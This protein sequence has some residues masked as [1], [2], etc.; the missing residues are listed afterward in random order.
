MFN[1]F[2]K[3]TDH[4]ANAAAIKVE[5]A[6]AAAGWAAYDAKMIV[7]RAKFAA[8]DAEMTAAGY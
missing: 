4:F 6:Q 7:V 2:N 5:G 3:K 8:L 1:L